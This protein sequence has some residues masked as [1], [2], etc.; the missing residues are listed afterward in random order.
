MIVE[1]KKDSI[2]II[3][4]KLIKLKLTLLIAGA[5]M[6]RAFSTMNIVKSNRIRNEK[7]VVKRLFVNIYYVRII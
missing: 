3:V 4:H 1:K 6:E 5:S 7:S 2:Y